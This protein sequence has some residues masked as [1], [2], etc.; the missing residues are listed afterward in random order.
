MAVALSELLKK[1]I[2]MSGSD[3]HITTNSPPQVR[4]HGHLT[5]LDLPPLTAAETKQLA[6]SVLTDA[7]KQ[8]F[9]ETLELDFSFGLRG[10]AR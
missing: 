7:Q 8:R 5:P 3:L 2:E 4:V 9:E 10:L 1:M 6:Y